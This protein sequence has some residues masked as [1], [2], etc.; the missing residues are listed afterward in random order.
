M[1]NATTLCLKFHN[2]LKSAS[3]RIYK[4]II[5]KITCFQSGVMRP[6]TCLWS[7][8]LDFQV[9]YG[10]PDSQ[11]DVLSKIPLK[12]ALYLDL[13]LLTEFMIKLICRVLCIWADD[14]VML[15]GFS[16]VPI[17]WYKNGSHDIYLNVNPFCLRL[18]YGNLDCISASSFWY[19]CKLE[20]LKTYMNKIKY[21][22][23]IPCKAAYEYL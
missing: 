16:R 3:F 21:F 13:V 7:W 10:P 12:T 8:A 9:N 2:Y 17:S 11:P 15:S 1:T 4:H 23:F 20:R 5:I 14:I 22:P 18:F 19:L 6:A